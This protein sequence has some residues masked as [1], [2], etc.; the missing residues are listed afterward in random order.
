MSKII[1]TTIHWVDLHSDSLVILLGGLTGALWK[2]DLLQVFHDLCTLQ[3]IEG[4]I[5]VGLKA[6]IGAL[7][8]WVVKTVC[9]YFKCKRKKNRHNGKNNN[10][11]KKHDVTGP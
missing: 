7:V 1:S 10:L 5:I 4:A 9:N 3:N 8:A 6:L 2:A 11:N